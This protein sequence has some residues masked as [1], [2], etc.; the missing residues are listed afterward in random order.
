MLTKIFLVVTSIHFTR[1]TLRALAMGY[2]QGFDTP[3]LGIAQGLG[4]TMMVKKNVPTNKDATEF[5]ER[6]VEVAN[7]EAVTW[8]VRL[9]V[10]GAQFLTN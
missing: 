1:L 4:L 9:K 2:H 6:D 7:P 5:K 10:F 3:A 8:W